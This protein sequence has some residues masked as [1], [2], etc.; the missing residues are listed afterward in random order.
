MTNAAQTALK[1]L[2]SLPEEIQDRVVQSLAGI[3][4]EARD[5]GRWDEAF[6]ERSDGLAAAARRAHEEIAA[7]K[8]R[9]MEYDKL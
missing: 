7:G 9:P 4:E 8:S 3:I 1:M 6:V 5:E 2:E